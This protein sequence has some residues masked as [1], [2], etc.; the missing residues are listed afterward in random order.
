MRGPDQTLTGNGF[1][2]F[3]NPDTAPGWPC[4]VLVRRAQMISTAGVVRSPVILVR[5]EVYTD[6]EI[7]RVNPDGESKI[8]PNGH[9]EWQWAKETLA[10]LRTGRP[11]PADLVRWKVRPGSRRVEYNGARLASTK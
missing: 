11:V 9:P 5:Y 10:A 3:F 7:R 6:G 1:V 4:V 8:V 2:L